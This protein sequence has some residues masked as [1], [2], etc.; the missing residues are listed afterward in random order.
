MNTH[1]KTIGKSLFV[2]TVTIV[3]LTLSHGVA[4]ADE[5]TISGN[6]GGCF[7][8]TPLSPC[9]PASG[10]QSQTAS[11]SG[12]HYNGS[13]FNV[14]TSLRFAAV[15]N[16]ANPPNN[17][18]NFG[19][20]TLDSTPITF[21][22]P[23]VNTF[24]LRLS[25]ILPVDSAP[26]SGTFTAELFGSVTDTNSGGVEIIFTNPQQRFTF[27]NGNSQFFVNLN[28][29]AITAGQG[30][31][32]L[33]GYIQTDTKPVPEPATLVLLGAGLAGIAAKLRG[34]KWPFRS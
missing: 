25:F 14:T 11:L 9:T 22:G 32:A 16:Q 31:V 34:R 3:F 23:K 19:S 30:P 18:N 8:T 6:S 27:D 17:F 20:F 33:S 7:Q 10:G 28:N 24:G 5:V 13:V 21:G 29:V 15:G 1:L 26:Q 12:L 2:S 4:R